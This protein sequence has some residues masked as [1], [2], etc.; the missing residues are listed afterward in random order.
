MIIGWDMDDDG[1]YLLVD[2]DDQFVFEQCEGF[3][4]VFDVVEGGD[5]WEVVYFY[6]CKFGIVIK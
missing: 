5:Y 6:V 3:Q 4:V 1:V 2:I